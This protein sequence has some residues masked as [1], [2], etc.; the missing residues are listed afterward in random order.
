MIRNQDLE[1][2]NNLYN[3]NSNDVVI[4][5]GNSKSCITDLYMEFMKGKKSFYYNATEVEFSIQSD[6]FSN[7]LH[8]Q[9]IIPKYISQSYDKLLLT[10][11]QED[12]SS[13]KVVIIDDFIK[14]LSINPTFISYILN[15]ISDKCKR[16]SVLFVLSTN[17][18]KWI[19]ND[20]FKILGNIT[21]EF[22]S[23]YKIK[24]F[25]IFETI[26]Y[27]NKLSA[28][29]CYLLYNIIGGNHCFWDIIKDCNSF[30]ECIVKLFDNCNNLEYE[31]KYIL[32]ED[33]RNPAVYNTILY[34]L[35][36]GA[37]KLNDLHA[38]TGIDRSKL[39]VYIKKLITF[40]IIS[41][42]EGIEIGKES[43][44]QKGCYGINDPFIRFWYHYIFPNY[45]SYKMMSSD[46]FFKKYIEPTLNVF[47]EL[48]YTQYCIEKFQIILSKGEFNFNYT[49]INVYYDKTDNISFIIKMADNSNI[50]CA[51]SLDKINLSIK[52][53]DKIKE[54]A[55][56]NDISYS[57]IILF[58]A[59]GFDQKLIL[60]SREDKNIILI[61]E[62][63]HWNFA[64][65][66]N[67]V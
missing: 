33:L 27:C 64:N 56:K 54:T 43:N 49:D 14:I 59:N 42:Y 19:E 37:N 29:E 9:N 13:K 22:S 40:N 5:Y 51:C 24:P 8:N 10:Y 1:Y 36:Q 34:A 45:S 50:L 52:K 11:L 18:E 30:R 32:P 61:D 41:K 57:K 60:C 7:E 17:N 20:M 35:S 47:S 38:L 48:T 58:S 16:A 21:Y 23:I 65:H 63:E 67:G 6:L 66:K 2:L 39:S 44:I 26:N 28:Y 3:R 53:L 62:A 15:I 46:K 31:G 4:V 55:D 12:F 25:S